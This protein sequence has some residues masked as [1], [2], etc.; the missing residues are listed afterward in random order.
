MTLHKKGLATALPTGS[1]PQIASGFALRALALLALCASACGGGPA[2]GGPGGPGGGS[3]P[4]MP[5]GMVTLAQKPVEQT[6]E[7]VASVKSRSSVTVQPQVDGIITRISVRSGNRVAAG[8][9]LFEI[10]SAQQQAAVASQQSMKAMRQAEVENARRQATRTKR[11]FEVGAASQRDAE[12]ADTALKTAEAQLKAVDEQVRQQSAQLGYYKVTAPASGVVGDIPVHPGDRVTTA[13]MLTTLDQNDALEIYVNVPVS[14]APQLKVGLPVR[15]V[16]GGNILATNRITF[17]SPNVDDTTQ[18]IL[19]KATLVE[20]RGRFRPDQFVRAEIVWSSD[21]GL[22]IPLTA[23]IRVN[24]QYFAW[25]A[26]SDG[27]GGLLA[28]QRGIEVGDLIGNDYVVT[29]GLKPGEKL[30]VSGLQKIFA[31]KSPVSEAPPEGAGEQKPEDT[32]KPEDS[33]VK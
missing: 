21:P 20:G 24:G 30:I 3:M 22:T 7:F 25:I 19:A 11:L 14:Q 13:T 26:E 32:K 29:K 27:K 28:T 23:V 6:T 8:A 17:V 18:T 2:Q 4:P 33:K 15:I 12:D 31:D 5:V 10:D 16:D 9:T 1:H